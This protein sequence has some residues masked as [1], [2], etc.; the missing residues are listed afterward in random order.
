VALIKQQLVQSGPHGEAWQV[1]LPTYAMVH[2]DYEAG[3]AIVEVPG[4][5]PGLT[6]EDLAHETLE[7]H[8]VGKH[9]TTLCDTCVSKVHTHL[10]DTYQEHEGKFRLRFA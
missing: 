5:I 2:V 4:G 1:L 7:E 6:E 3:Y 9:Y 10:D 8:A